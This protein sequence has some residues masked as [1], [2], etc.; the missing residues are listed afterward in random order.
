MV[1]AANGTLWTMGPGDDMIAVELYAK[2]GSEK[3]DEEEDDDEDE[4]EEAARE[5]FANLAI[6][7]GA[8]VV[9]KDF[10]YGQAA[11]NDLLDSADE[12]HVARLLQK[13]QAQQ[14]GEPAR[15]GAAKLAEAEAEEKTESVF[16]PL[17]HSPFLIPPSH[18]LPSHDIAP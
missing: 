3:Q 2:K 14:R 4:D 5:G 8:P 11:Y 16:F 10:A 15:G 9:I 13:Q 7:R 17:P 18:P 12:T 6:R 1:D